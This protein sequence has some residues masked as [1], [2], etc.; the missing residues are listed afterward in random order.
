M[1]IYH[2]FLINVFRKL[3]CQLYIEYTHGGCTR[4]RDTHEGT[5]TQRDMCMNEQTYGATYSYIEGRGPYLEDL[6]I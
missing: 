5:Y 1:S 6:Y 3:P 4:R 2:S